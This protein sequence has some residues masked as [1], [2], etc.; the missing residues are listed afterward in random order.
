MEEKPVFNDH[1]TYSEKELYAR[2][3][4]GDEQAFLLLFKT[5][6]P[7]IRPFTRKI[8]N[9]EADAEDVIQEVFVRIWLYRDRFTEIENLKS[10]IFTVTANECMRYMRQKLTYERK[11]DELV[12]RQP[13]PENNTP[14]EYAQLNQISRF[15]K[16][17]VEGMPAQ[18]KKIYSLS[19]D[20]GM[21]PAAIA[22]ALS[23]S[24]GTVKNVLSRA[25]NDIRDHLVASGISLSVMLFL[26]R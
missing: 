13:S 9:S 6:S 7:M 3:A 25:L 20:H 5:F 24:V 2:I 11:T 19:R 10:W 18:R 4:D 14:L 21:K 12:H 26:L 23:L 8:T 1:Q 22:A 17:A 16:E 15:V